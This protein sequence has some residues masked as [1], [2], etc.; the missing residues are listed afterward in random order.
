MNKYDLTT[1]SGLQ[2]AKGA[3]MDG[4]MNYNP[5][6]GLAYKAIIKL[7]DSGKDSIEVQRKTAEALIKQGKDSGADEIEIK[8][9][10]TNGFKLKVPLEEC[11]IDTMLGNDNEMTI[12]VKYK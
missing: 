9:K 5:L 11:N 7:I 1:Q 2:L 4:F 12:K 6:I 10:T 3:I 8:L